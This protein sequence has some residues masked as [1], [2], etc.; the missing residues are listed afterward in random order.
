MWIWPSS[1]LRPPAATAPTSASNATGARPST[2]ARA[3]ARLQPASTEHAPLWATA[4][5]ATRRKEAGPDC[6]GAGACAALGGP[7]A[8]GLGRSRTD[9]APRAPVLP[10]DP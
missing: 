7:T 4:G 3:R 1:R 5:R 10:L 9:T 8:R 6:A 2:C